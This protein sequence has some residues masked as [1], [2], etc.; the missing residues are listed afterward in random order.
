[1]KRSIFLG[2]LLCVALNAFADSRDT[3]LQLLEQGKFVELE[4]HLTSWTRLE[5]KNPEVYIAWFNYYINR[6]M[7]T[8]IAIDSSVD[9]RK[10]HMVITDPKTGK[11]LGYMGDKVYYDYADVQ[12]ALRYLDTGLRLA[13]DRLDMYMGKI[14][15]LG[16]TGE[17]GKQAEVVALVL[18]KG[19]AK[20]HRWLWSRNEP[21]SDGKQFLLDNVQGYYDLW[22]GRDTPQ[23]LAAAVSVATRQVELYADDMYAYNILSYCYTMQGRPD[24]ALKLLLKAHS[25]NKADSVITGNLAMLYRDLKDIDNARLYFNELLADADPGVTAWARKMLKELH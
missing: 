11:V 20:K 1:M 4:R 18:E 8:G 12:N 21:M 15:I 7:K 6:S 10:P 13:P 23:S 25:I 2:V 5:G 9:T 17:F 14:H 3:Y 24:D 19:A 16:E 22:L